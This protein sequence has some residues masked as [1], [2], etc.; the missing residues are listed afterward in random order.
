MQHSIYMSNVPSDKDARN[1]FVAFMT[2]M[3]RGFRGLR[4]RKNGS[5]VKVLQNQDSVVVRIHDTLYNVEIIKAEVLHKKR[6]PPIPSYTLYA[7]VH[8]DMRYFRGVRGLAEFKKLMQGKTMSPEDCKKLE[9]YTTRIALSEA[10]IAAA[11][12]RQARRD[13]IRK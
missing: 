12:Q 8:G 13:E 4:L 3:R 6:D 11:R 7:N 5:A 10:V 2:F 1:R 9:A